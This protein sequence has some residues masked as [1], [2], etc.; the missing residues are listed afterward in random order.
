MRELLSSRWVRIVAG[1][2]VA[3]AATVFTCG[4][5]PVSPFAEWPNG[6]IFLPAVPA[7]APFI[8]LVLSLPGQSRRR[9]RKAQPWEL[10][11]E[12]PSYKF[13]WRDV[14][15]KRSATVAGIIAVVV[16]ISFFEYFFGSYEGQP[17]MVDGRYALTDHGNLIRFVTRHEWLVRRTYET[18]IL[19]GHIMLFGTVGLLAKVDPKPGPAQT[20]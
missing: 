10:P 11:M 6:A 16:A 13:R 3:F 15:S 14:L 19:A 12:E 1:C 5:F 20:V 17:H 9:N 18:R 2:S 8:G 4:F 7:V